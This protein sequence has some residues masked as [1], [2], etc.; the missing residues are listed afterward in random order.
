MNIEDMTY[1]DFLK[2]PHRKWDEDVVCDSIV[3]LPMK[4]NNWQML[5]Y[6]V[7]KYLS[8]KW[9]IFKEPEIYEVF[10]M[11]DS[12]FRTMD[13]VAIKDRK[14]VCLLAGGSDV[15]H[16]DG[17]GGFGKDWLDKYHTVP[18]MVPVSGWNIDC[19]PKS[20]LLHLWGHKEMVCDSGY[21]SFEVFIN[22]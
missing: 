17:I 18:K 19:L 3:I 4:I 22:Q 16:L 13:F 14:P 7:R 20:G 10:G 1:D 8:S 21:S 5:W 12:G 2:L 11:H 9:S 15:I 6:N